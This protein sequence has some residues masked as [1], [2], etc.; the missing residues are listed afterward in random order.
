LGQ[1]NPYLSPHSLYLVLG[2]DDK[3]RQA[4][5]RS[6]FRAELDNEAIND[7]RLALRSCLKIPQ[8]STRQGENRRESAVY[9]RVTEHF[10]WSFDAPT[11]IK[12]RAA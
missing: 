9:M 7:I 6:L 3:T 4:A 1:A 11:N 2:K 10:E 12:C 5:Y 8:A